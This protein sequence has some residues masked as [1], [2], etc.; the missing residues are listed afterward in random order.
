LPREHRRHE[1]EAAG[2][3]HSVPRR[4]DGAESRPGSDDGGRHGPSS[5]SSCDAESGS[6][7]SSSSPSGGSLDGGSSGGGL[8]GGSGDGGGVVGSGV[9][10]GEGGGGGGVGSGAG[11]GPSETTIVMDAPSSTR[12]PPAGV[13]EMTRPAATW[14]E[15]VS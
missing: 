2:Q 15:Y 14:S 5:S 9:G 6:P 3:G 7:S 10:S 1:S 8:D 13:T 12:S 11:S 4:A